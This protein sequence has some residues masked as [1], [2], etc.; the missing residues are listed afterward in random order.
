MW[1]SQ[2]SLIRRDRRNQQRTGSTVLKSARFAETLVIGSLALASLAASSVLVRGGD[3]E[4]ASSTDG[5]T[6]PAAPTRFVAEYRKSLDGLRE[7]IARLGG[8]LTGST[9][10][11]DSLRD[12][13][14]NQ[15]LTA[16]SASAAYETSKLTRE[17]AEIAVK[18]YEEG[19]FLQDLQTAQGELKLSEFDASRAVDEIEIAKQRLAAI[20]KASKGSAGDLVNQ[21]SFE[22]AVSDAERRE[23]RARLALAAAR[24]KLEKLEKYTR[25]RRL[26]ELRA[27]VEQARAGELLKQSQMEAEKLKLKNLEEAIKAG[28]RPIHE[29]RLLAVLGQAIELTDQL[30]AKLDHVKTEAEAGESLRAEIA[31]L[32]KQ[33][34][35]TVESARNE[36][37]AAAWNRLKSKI[38]AAAKGDPSAKPK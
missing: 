20:K 17:V 35:A 31:R 15:Q 12:A 5:A 23:P 14:V 37:A 1:P 11:V 29:Q 26:N 7:E 34:D 8:V 24:A 25:P 4:L 3:Q 9:G 30:E 16:M 28:G 36:H 21:Y 22:D 38:P 19:I 32:L 33:L 2:F 13:A 10:S 18:E 27:E 6:A